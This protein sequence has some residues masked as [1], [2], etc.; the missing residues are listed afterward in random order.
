MD[1]FKQ[2]SECDI[3]L[4]NDFPSLSA[5]LERHGV[6]SIDLISASLVHDGII[7]LARRL[8]RSSNEINA[9]TEMLKLTVNKGVKE[10]PIPDEA[11]DFYV[12]TEIP[13]LDAQLGGG[14]RTR[15]ITEL[16]GASGTGKSQMLLQMSIN[17]LSDD[18]RSKCVYV[19]T[20]STLPSGRLEE[21]I[22]MKELEPSIMNRILSIY[23]SDIEQQD[24]I[25][26]TQLP[27]LLEGD[28]HIKLVIIDSIS[29]HLRRDDYI[30]I[31]SYLESRI[32]EQEEVLLKTDQSAEI[33]KKHNFQLSRF[34]RFSPRYKRSILRTTYVSLLHKHLLQLARKHNLAVVLANQISDQ[35]S[36][37]HDRASNDGMSLD[38]DYQ[39]GSLL[40]W[41]NEV[42]LSHQFYE[43]SSG[44]ISGRLF[45]S[46]REG[47]KRQKTANS[48]EIQVETNSLIGTYQHHE[49]A[50]PDSTDSPPP[51]ILTKRHIPALGYQWLKSVPVRILLMKRYRFRALDSAC[52]DSLRGPTGEKNEKDLNNNNS[53]NNSAIHETIDAVNEAGDWQVERF[54]KVVTNFYSPK[55]IN[56]GLRD[57]I[58]L[59][60]S[61]LGF[62]EVQ[63]EI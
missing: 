32:K 20:E 58:E 4:E 49:F 36:Y 46:Q 51:T 8:G 39:I 23:C 14:A 28:Q 61:K 26:Y 59:C 34:F 13:S 57:G 62:H 5:T 44:P 1:I 12:R 2:A 47:R 3:R 9:Y 22:Q 50:L 17:C 18:D 16:F 45:S 21:M 29:H 43:E 52:H 48:D 7:R 42:L 33:K 63:H 6:T 54:T 31:T 53:S 27:L 37:P 30:S 15:D 41:D 55:S 10:E 25:F 19:S 38:L 60:L 35:P 56:G 24:H 40:G 11:S